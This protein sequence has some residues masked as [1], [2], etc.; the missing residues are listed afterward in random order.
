MSTGTDFAEHDLRSDRHAKELRF[1]RATV[2]CTWSSGKDMLAN[3]RMERTRR[4]S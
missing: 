2:W 1:R 3:Q 4:E